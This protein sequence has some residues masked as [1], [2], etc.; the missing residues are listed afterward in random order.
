LAADLKPA[1][2]AG[3][4]D[5]S[6]S[7]EGATNAMHTHAVAHRSDQRHDAPLSAGAQSTVS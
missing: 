3:G 1:R 5:R 2:E 6:I 7:D 4:D